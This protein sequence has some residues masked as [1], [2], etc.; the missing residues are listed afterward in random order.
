VAIP[1]SWGYLYAH[2]EHLTSKLVG[3]E[4]NGKPLINANRRRVAEILSA[5]NSKHEYRNPTCPSEGGNKSELQKQR[6]FSENRQFIIF[7]FEF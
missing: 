1:R 6:K 2:F 4:R 7:D 5:P 3:K